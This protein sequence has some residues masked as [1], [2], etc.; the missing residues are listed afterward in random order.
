MTANLLLSARWLLALVLLTAASFKLFGQTQEQRIEAIRR[1]EIV[2]HG[3][4]PLAAWCLPWVEA[5]LGV[6]LAAGFLVSITALLSGLLLAG[7][8]GV[9]SWHLVS[10]RQF[11]CGCGTGHQR[12]ISW[13]LVTGDAALTV[14]AVIVAIGP[15]GE[16]AVF[17]GWAMSRTH[18]KPVAQT[19]AMPLLAVLVV[20]SWPL[21]KL[22]PHHRA[23]AWRQV[24]RRGDEASFRPT[25]VR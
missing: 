24:H 23:L 6:G 11:D 3:S 9:M 16:L 2:P 7:F 14:L 5:S 4:L 17:P 21:L 12:D 1:Y 13:L 25:E 15:G 19:L 22:I 20:V 18:S 8:A 10:G